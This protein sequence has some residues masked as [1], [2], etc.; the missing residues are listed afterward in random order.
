MPKTRG[1]TAI[2][3]DRLVKAKIEQAV[4]YKGQ[5]LSAAAITLDANEHTI[6]VVGG[7]QDG[8]SCTNRQAVGGSEGVV[9]ALNQKRSRRCWWTTG[10]R[11]CCWRA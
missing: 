11:C 3:K 1:V 6:S 4:A 5:A 10:G 2:Q 7:S 8:F 9:I